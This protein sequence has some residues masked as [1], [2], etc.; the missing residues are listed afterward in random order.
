MFF[1]IGYIKR[2]CRFISALACA[3]GLAIAAA[4]VPHAQ[5]G[6]AAGNIEEAIAWHN[7]GRAGAARSTERA[8][9]VLLGLLEADPENARAMAYL[10][11]SYALVARDSAAAADK[12]RYT[13]RGLRYLDQAVSMD[14][15]SFELLLIRARVAADLPDMFGR[16]DNAIKDMLTLDA[17][18]SRFRDPRMAGA[19]AGIYAKLA[20]LA[21]QQGDWLDKAASAKALI[22]VK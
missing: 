9:E 16:R 17:M 2:L 20:E 18:F 11:S 12:I 6:S 13:N 14:P 10:G 1:K 4:G 5:A 3:A 8:V 19:M 21:P 7:A 22:P 15:D